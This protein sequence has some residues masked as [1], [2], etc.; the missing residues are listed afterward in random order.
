MDVNEGPRCY[1]ICPL[2]RT[3][4]GPYK[5][6][7]IHFG[8]LGINGNALPWPVEASEEIWQCLV[9]PTFDSAR[10]YRVRRG[11]LFLKAWCYNPRVRDKFK[12]RLNYRRAKC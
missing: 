12:T 3:E 2:G 1:L 4:Y 10:P 11:R 5:A 8:V 9:R 6:R 7:V